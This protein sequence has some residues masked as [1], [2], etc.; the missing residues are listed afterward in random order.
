MPQRSSTDLPRGGESG[1]H[2]DG[3]V[4]FV[5]DMHQVPG[6]GC[7][8]LFVLIYGL[9]FVIPFCWMVYTSVEQH[10]PEGTAPYLVAS[11]L[12]LGLSAWYLRRRAGQAKEREA[13]RH[14]QIELEREEDRRFSALALDR[15]DAMELG[16]FERYVADVL[17]Q[18]GL[19][20]AAT[21][22]DDGRAARARFV[23]TSEAG[24]RHAVC[25]QRTC[26]E[27]VRAGA[28]R[29]ALAA[30]RSLRCEGAMVISDGYFARD[31]AK[32]ARRCVLVDRDTLDGWVRQLQTLRPPPA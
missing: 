3:L 10:V 24:E 23:A 6:C 16:A 18:R 27:P 22:G 13:W 26:G 19:R 29:A 11:V 32:L 5:H 17:R 8:A 30:R 1:R 4:E 20:V 14:H 12:G 9:V 28:V 2:H 25:I 15:V 7:L 31:A 21:P